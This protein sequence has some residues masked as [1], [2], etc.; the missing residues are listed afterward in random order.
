MNI[1]VDVSDNLSKGGIV[2][3][4]LLGGV[5]AAAV[6]LYLVLLFSRVL[7]VKIEEKKYDKYCEKYRAEHGGEEGM[8]SKEDFIRN[9]ADGKAVVWTRDDGPSADRA[10]KASS[11]ESPSVEATEQEDAPT[12]P[13]QNEDETPVTPSQPDSER[14]ND[15]NAP[16]ERNADDANR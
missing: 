11:T 6:I 15:A 2:A 13:A 16:T 9:R 3:L 7:G 12:L 5:V 10:A 8:L 1:L 14:E 4:K